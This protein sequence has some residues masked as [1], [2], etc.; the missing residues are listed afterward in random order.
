MNVNAILTALRRHRF[1][2]RWFAGGLLLV[3]IVTLAVMHSRSKA[4]APTTSV[5]TAT[6]RR[7]EF[8]VIISC[9]G[10]LT[11]DKTARIN[12]PVNVPNLQ[13]VWLAPQGSAVRNGDPVVRFD[14]SGTQRQL[15]EQEAAL[16]QAQASLDQAIAEGKITTEQDKLDLAAQ[17]Q[18]AEKARLEAS[19]K[20]IVSDI[21]AQ[22][23][24]ID[25]GLAQE[26]VRVQQATMEL[27]AA[28]NRS[29]VGSL[30]SQRNKAK[31][32]VDVTRQRL[33]SMEV[34]APAAGVVSYLMN[35]SQ[36]WMNAK[37]F[38][39][40]DNLWP[41][42]AIAEIPDLGSLRLKGKVEEIDRGK[43]Q[44]G[45]DV[46]VMLDPFPEKPFAGKLEAISP[47]T[48]QTFEWPPSRSFRAFGSL[49]ARDDRLRPAM[50]GRMDV[51]VDRLHNVISVPAKAV[52]AHDGRPVVLVPAKEGLRSVRVEVLARN[53]DE[54]AIA[55][56]EPGTQ[57]ALVDTLSLEKKK[58][59]ESK[60]FEVKAR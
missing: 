26:K 19:K 16:A 57:V 28:S 38:K 44:L 48:E 30:Q 24:V 23:N 6:A 50:N 34:R 39:V 49:G 21:Q 31:E 8:L 27:N 25:L 14:A 51:I 9:R 46:R 4:A 59:R 54:V 2:K 20:D 22:E 11:A 15:K 52:F 37:P 12:A 36:G 29:K 58:N 7:G 60:G 45:Q 1:G 42:S 43:L 33:A 18:A 13:I 35:F 53:P 47:L 40:G 10:E 3:L 32:L 56:I 55:G 5:P 41:G 17:R